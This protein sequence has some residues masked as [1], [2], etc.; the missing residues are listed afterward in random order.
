MNDLRAR[1]VRTVGIL[2]MGSSR[3][4]QPLVSDNPAKFAN[5][6]NRFYTDKTL[7]TIGMNVIDYVKQ[8]A[9]TQVESG[10]VGCFSRINPKQSVWTR[11]L[12]G[13]CY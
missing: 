10:V 2:M 11:W 7:L 5:Y 3:I 12:T 13:P 4:E 1:W 6:L 9:V 8:Q